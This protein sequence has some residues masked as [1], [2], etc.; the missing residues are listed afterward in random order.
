M[1]AFAAAGASH[2]AMARAAELL[3]MVESRF[4][5]DCPV[6]STPG[7][8]FKLHDLSRAQSF[9]SHDWIDTICVGWVGSAAIWPMGWVVAGSSD[10]LGGRRV[11]R[12]VSHTK[13]SRL[14]AEIAT[15]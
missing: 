12:S 2:H 8:R 1:K 10:G 13:T 5:P 3:V 6:R 7:F 11:Q 9:V 15:E 14:Q 4:Q